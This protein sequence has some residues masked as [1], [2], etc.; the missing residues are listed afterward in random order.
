LLNFVTLS[1]V[2]L[3]PLNAWTIVI[4]GAGGVMAVQGRLGWA[5]SLVVLGAAPALLGGVGLLYGP[6]VFLI[7]CAGLLPVRTPQPR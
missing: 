7:A 2:G 6:S 5:L 1:D 3:N 4:C